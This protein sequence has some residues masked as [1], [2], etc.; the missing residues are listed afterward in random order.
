M[1]IGKKRAWLALALVAVAAVIA[2]WWTARNRV[3]PVILTLPDGQ[4]FRF[5]GVTYGTKNTPPIFLARLA[6][7]LPTNLAKY[8]RS[9]AGTR[10]NQPTPTIVLSEPQY[11]VWF[12][13]TGSN[14]VPANSTQMLQALVSDELGA[15]GGQSSAD[16]FASATIWANLTFSVVPRRSRII[17]LKFYP[18]PVTNS[19]AVAQVRFPNPFYG[20]YPQ[21]RSEP[22]PAVKQV[23][24]LEVRLENFATGV[25]Q[26]ELPRVLGNG[27]QGVNFRP[28]HEG[29][30]AVPYFDVL[31]RS[32]R[33]TNEAWVV[34][35]YELSD[36]TG[37]VLSRPLSSSPGNWA[38]PVTLMG[39]Y[40]FVLPGTLWPGENAWRLKL[41]LKRKAGFPPEDVTTFGKVPVPAAGTI[42]TTPI[43]NMAGGMRV[44]LTKFG[45]N[46]AIIAYGLTTQIGG[47]EIEVE[48]PDHPEGVT[49]D[50]VKLTTDAGDELKATRNDWSPFGHIFHLP[51][52]P[53]NAKTVDLT[54]VVQKTRTV[55]FLVKPPN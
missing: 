6:E 2:V 5:V 31:A 18:I 42:S 41:E 44:V 22:L 23:G 1:R 28:A 52:I 50:L 45:G 3:P 49:V 39:E 4:Q 16:A 29:E 8:V 35:A 26:R 19:Q 9:H 32:T 17:Q 48:L 33:D 10:L 25:A 30:Y 47:A 21:W 24:D 40:R 12:Q 34:Q 27:R 36:A 37:N 54:L 38:S 51:A 46:G 53:T 11:V 55:E 43:M 14:A 15:E 20:H 7:W 13:R